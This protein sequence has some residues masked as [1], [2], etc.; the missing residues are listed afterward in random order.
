MG[1]I[2]RFDIPTQGSGDGNLPGVSELRGAA[3]RSE[4]EKVG[5]RVVREWT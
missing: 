3:G 4:G 5:P 2:Q 1:D